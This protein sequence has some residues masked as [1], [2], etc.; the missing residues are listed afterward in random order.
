[1]QAGRVP[2]FQRLPIITRDASSATSVFILHPIADYIQRNRPDPDESGRYLA[3]G[4][5]KFRT[6]ACLP[7]ARIEAHA[8]T[9]PG[10]NFHRADSCRRRL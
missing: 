4:L 10:Q 6:R 2:S 1:M 9:L 3:W 5:S 8:R 7:V